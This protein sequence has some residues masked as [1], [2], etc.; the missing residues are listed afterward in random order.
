MGQRRHLQR[1]WELSLPDGSGQPSDDLLH[2]LVHGDPLRAPESVAASCLLGVWNAVGD[3]EHAVQ[4][5][6]GA[7]ALQ[8]DLAKQSRGLSWLRRVQRHCERVAEEAP[9]RDRA[10]QVRAD[11]ADAHRRAEVRQ[12]PR[13][14]GHRVGAASVTRVLRAVLTIAGEAGRTRGLHLSVRTV[15]ERAGVSRGTAQSALGYLQSARVL[16]RL[17]RH[18]VRDGQVRAATYS[19]ELDH[20]VLPDDSAE[21]THTVQV[22][23]TSLL[24]HDAWRWGGL[25]GAAGHVW[26]LLSDTDGL[27]V[28]QVAGL[29]GVSVSWTARL[30]ARLAQHG[31]AVRRGDTWTRCTLAQAQDRLD[32]AARHV[33]TAGK[34]DAVRAKHEQERAAWSEART[35]W[36]ATR[37]Q[38]D[39]QP[40]GAV[41]DPSTGVW[42]DLST[43]EV[44]AAPAEV[45]PPPL[46]PVGLTAEELRRQDAL[47]RE[48][49]AQVRADQRERGAALAD[50]LHARLD[51]RDP[52]V[53]D[54]SDPG[55]PARTYLRTL[56]VQRQ[57]ELLRD[58]FAVVAGSPRLQELA[59][60]LQDTFA[61]LADVGRPLQELADRMGATLAAVASSAEEGRDD[62]DPGT[63]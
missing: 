48:R 55:V 7:P 50:R 60:Q 26:V 43:G 35:R 20:Y 3:W 21:D 39:R 49:D 13:L 32:V 63:P 8:S 10:H 61:H 12:W 14:D 54:L 24:S 52:A 37:S 40:V 1:S 15:A 62:R 51:D 29:R 17:D 6:A 38:Q 42:V 19:L 25:G 47:Q 53:L 23:A 33:G 11:L 9:D 45:G 16:V 44:V 34:G 27:T 28:T 56:T 5:V 58:T 4:V 57:A 36:V 46:E 22:A 41:R 18:Q 2:L 59:T 31:L 30:L